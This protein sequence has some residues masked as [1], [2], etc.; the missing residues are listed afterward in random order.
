[1]LLK[2]AVG[3]LLL[4]IGM[5]S[6]FGD[7]IYIWRRPG[8]LVRS[9][10]AMYL[11]V[12]MAA[13]LLVRFLPIGISVKAALLVLA[14]SAGAPLLPRKLGSFGNGA[15]VFSLVVT[16]SLLALIVVPLWISLLS[17]YFGVASDLQPGT[18]AL[19]IG[20]S[21]LAPLLLGMLIRKI[22]P[23][24]GERLS[25]RI[26][27]I[28]GIVL[29]ACALVLLV[30]HWDLF[31][32]VSWKGMAILVALML[33]A[34]AIGHA[35]GGPTPED[36]TVLAV[37]CATRHIGIAVLV[38]ATFPGPGTAVLIVA[39]VVASAAVS[40][41]YLKWRLRKS[42]HTRQAEPL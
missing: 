24:I 1:M 22:F 38:A 32:A 6:T 37:A 25:D 21:F 5:G 9:L 23:A 18:V 4:A 17:R 26:L 3:A 27:S 36:R 7:L 2:V 42:A 12:P 16:S 35:V 31:L 14:V 40:I 34:L 28:A 39:Y 41:P 33:I 20:K 8:L 15:Y 30:T 11:L 29:T 19:V 10:L 13:F